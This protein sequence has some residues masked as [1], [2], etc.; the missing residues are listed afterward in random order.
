MFDLILPLKVQ[1]LPTESS[2][3][4]VSLSDFVLEKRDGKR[5]KETRMK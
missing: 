5:E 2:L 1:T 3:V 4:K